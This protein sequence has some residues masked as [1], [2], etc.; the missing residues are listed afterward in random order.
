V[1]RFLHDALTLTVATGGIVAVIVAAT[2]LGFR[3][4]KGLEEP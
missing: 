1:T 3:R 2:R 4:G